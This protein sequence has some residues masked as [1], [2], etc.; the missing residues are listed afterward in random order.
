[1]VI[2]HSVD[3]KPNTVI[4][5]INNTQNNRSHSK[6]SGSNIN[7]A[8][9]NRL[10]LDD[11]NNPNQL[12]NNQLSTQSDQID[13]QPQVARIHSN[14]FY[15]STNLSE[16]S[17]FSMTSSL[18]SSTNTQQQQ[19]QQPHKQNHE[20]NTPQV[21]IIDVNNQNSNNKRVILNT[22]NV[23]VYVN[24]SD[25]QQIITNQPTST[26]IKIPTDDEIKYKF[27][28]TETIGNK[29]NTAA[30]DFDFVNES[31]ASSSKFSK[32]AKCFKCC[33]IS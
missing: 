4:K 9:P 3:D 6:A 2:N 26:N 31:D 32:C 15:N 10:Y 28:S 14:G 25:K 29:R 22:N 17:N 33:T 11:N 7:P 27:V 16:S 20:S 30:N 1:M 21:A 18:I 24:N 23:D 5:V 19:Q 13:H 12:K 8:N